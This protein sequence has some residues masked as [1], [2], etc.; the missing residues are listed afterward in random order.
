MSFAGIQNRLHA[1]HTF[2]N[3][4]FAR[5]RHIRVLQSHPNF[6][7][8]VFKIPRS[9][10]R[11]SAVLYD[12]VKPA[13]RRPTHEG[14]TTTKLLFFLD[15]MHRISGTKQ[16]ED[17]NNDRHGRDTRV[18]AQPGERPALF[19]ASTCSRRDAPTSCAR[20]ANSW[21]FSSILKKNKPIEEHQ[22]HYK[23]LPCP[24]THRV[25]DIYNNN[26][27][28]SAILTGLR[29]R[30]GDMDASLSPRHIFDVSNSELEE[31][32]G[33]ARR[34]R[35]F[36]SRTP[37]H[38]AYPSQPPPPGI[39]FNK[40]LLDYYAHGSGPGSIHSRTAGPPETRSAQTH[41]PRFRLP[42]G[43][44]AQVRGY[45]PTRSTTTSS[46]GCASSTCPPTTWCTI[47]TVRSLTPTNLRGSRSGSSSSSLL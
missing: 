25:C 28:M 46:R 17:V 3:G 20:C 6:N 29:N 24:S 39:F 36:R 7:H 9:V 10:M 41:H 14:S 43:F 19:A 30:R 45:V 13:A 5:C 21:H 34:Q 18:R 8:F 1:Q 23:I 22:H 32:S 31:E 44:T 2:K 12:T 26:T 15:L 38:A 35:R 11:K 33:H 27:K 40:Y 4:P 47:R 42:E 37:V 16:N